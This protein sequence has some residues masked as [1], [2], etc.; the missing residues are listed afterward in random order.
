MHGLHTCQS[1]IPILFL[2]VL[3]AEKLQQLTI[4]LFSSI[5]FFCE[6]LITVFKSFTHSHALLPLYSLQFF[7]AMQTH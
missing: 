2:H 1:P 6:L 4:I 5:I 7:G 3:M